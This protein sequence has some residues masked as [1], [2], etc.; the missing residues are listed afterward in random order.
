MTC[1][2]DGDGENYSCHWFG[3]L[4]LQGCRFGVGEQT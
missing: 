3:L 4:W 1:S 2:G